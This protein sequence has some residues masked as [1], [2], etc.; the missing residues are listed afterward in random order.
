MDEGLAR[1]GDDVILRPWFQDFWYDASQVRA[2]IDEAD[3]RGVGWML[4]HPGSN[5]TYDA[6]R[7]AA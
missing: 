7:P 3:T 5:F 2:Q 6:L 4:W 1:I